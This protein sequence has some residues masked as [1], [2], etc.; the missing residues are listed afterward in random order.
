MGRSRQR[1]HPAR[2]LIGTGLV[3]L[4]LA[5]VLVWPTAAGAATPAAVTVG[6]ATLTQ[7]A[8]APVA[9]CGHLSV[10]LDRTDPGSPHIPIAYRW[11]PATAPQGG[12]ASGTVVDGERVPG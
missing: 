6:T 3:G 4:V 7:C 10:P 12:V 1:G 9:Y 11:Y 2:R 5:S 8:T